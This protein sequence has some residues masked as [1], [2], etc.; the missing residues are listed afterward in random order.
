MRELA[1]PSKRLTSTFWPSLTQAQA[2]VGPCKQPMKNTTITYQLRP[3][4]ITL[5]SNGGVRPRVAA[6]RAGCGG[7]HHHHTTRAPGASLVSYDDDLGVLRWHPHRAIRPL[8]EP[9][10]QIAKVR[11]QRTL[12]GLLQRQERLVYRSVIGTEGIDEMVG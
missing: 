3:T 11:F 6:W 9:S 10:D 2:P 4:I 7:S 12:P 5:G 8:I 1:N